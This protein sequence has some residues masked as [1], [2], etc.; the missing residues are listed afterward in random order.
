MNTQFISLLLG[1]ITIMIIIYKLNESF[2]NVDSPNNSQLNLN[3]KY[4]AYNFNN[5]NEEYIIILYSQ[6]TFKLQEIVCDLIINNILPINKDLNDFYDLKDSAQYQIRV[7]PKNNIA[8]AIKLADFNNPDIIN[9]ESRLIFDDMNLP[10]YL[11]HSQTFKNVVD[12]N[13]NNN[14]NIRLQD[15]HNTLLLSSNNLNSIN[16]NTNG[17]LVGNKFV[18]LNNILD[19]P[20]Y[21][22]ILD[23]NNNGVIINKETIII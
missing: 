14:D 13:V 16:I 10:Y 22:I 3:K 2:E 6:L 7:L 17:N 15:I 11:M 23:N 1:I 19:L 4:Y 20:L 21:Q 12:I 9:F 8:F 18:K 5:N